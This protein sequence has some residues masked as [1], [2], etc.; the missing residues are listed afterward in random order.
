MRDL[1]SLAGVSV[2]VSTRHQSVSLAAD[3][4]ASTNQ[5]YRVLVQFRREIYPNFVLGTLGLKPR[6]MRAIALWPPED[7][8]LPVHRI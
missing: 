4:T 6:G 7:I 8:P 2:V 5:A 3:R 1:I